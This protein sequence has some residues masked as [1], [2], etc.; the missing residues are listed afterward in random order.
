M[1]RACLL[2]LVAAL[3]FVAAPGTAAA[4]SASG[5][6]RRP[7]PEAWSAQ[8]RASAAPVSQEDASLIAANMQ[9]LGE[10]CGLTAPELDRLAATSNHDG[11]VTAADIRS[12]LPA[13][14]RRA[15]EQRRTPDFAQK[16]DLLRFRLETGR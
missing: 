5:A 15:D 14:R 1:Q 9:A 2:P 6:D 16:C 10:T 12:H 13:A 8:Q 7:S 3:L 4:Q 11:A